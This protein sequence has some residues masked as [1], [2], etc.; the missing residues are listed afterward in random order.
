MSNIICACGATPS[1]IVACSG[2]ADVGEL[3]DLAAR[4]LSRD[5]KGAMFCLAG[6]GARISGFVKSA[7]G[8]GNILVIDGCPLNCAAKTLKEVSVEKI[9]HVTVTEL[10]LVKGQCGI[11]DAN[12][13]KIYDKACDLLKESTKSD[14]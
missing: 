5:K 10:G 2:A 4:K 9:M 11:S 3:A 1:L 14:Q 8:A 6:V 12:V 13:A 7:E